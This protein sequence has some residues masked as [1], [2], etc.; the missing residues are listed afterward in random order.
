MLQ[1]SS[2]AL[3]PLRVHVAPTLIRVLSCYSLASFRMAS[4]PLPIDPCLVRSLS[5]AHQPQQ[6]LFKSQPTQPQALSA[7]PFPCP[8]GP[9][10]QERCSFLGHCL[11]VSTPVMSH[12]YPLPRH[13]PTPNAWPGKIE[14]LGEAELSRDGLSS[15]TLWLWL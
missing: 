2:K 9:T 4:G 1:E 13:T 5:E 6:T 8:S 15:L 14:G 11:W 12:Y 7:V 10:A 3:F